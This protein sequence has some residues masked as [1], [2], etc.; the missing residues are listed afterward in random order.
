LS[1]SPRAAVSLTG[2]QHEDCFVVSRDAD[3]GVLD[4]AATG[5]PGAIGMWKAEASNLRLGQRCGSRCVGPDHG[6]AGMGRTGKGSAAHSAAPLEKGGS[7]GGL[8]RNRR[9]KTA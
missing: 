9:T 7:P 8:K 1:A 4:S 5:W 6:T 3:W 2:R